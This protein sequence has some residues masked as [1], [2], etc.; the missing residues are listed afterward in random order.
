[1]YDETENARRARIG[2]LNTGLTENKDARRAE[3]EAQYGKVWDTTTLSQEFR[4]IGFMAPFV[5]VEEKASGKK[6][7]LEFCHSPR[8]YF[9]FVADE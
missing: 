6:G 3:L 4:V 1:M 9:S 5:V 8:F 2:E 7:S